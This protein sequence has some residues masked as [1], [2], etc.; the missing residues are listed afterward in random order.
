MSLLSVQERDGQHALAVEEIRRDLKFVKSVGDRLICA[1]CQ[2]CIF[3]G[4]PTSHNPANVPLV[5][6]V[7]V[8]NL[9]R[10]RPL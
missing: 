2:G 9:M 7:A 10:I 1:L 6:P 3:C 5:P 8:S 4:S